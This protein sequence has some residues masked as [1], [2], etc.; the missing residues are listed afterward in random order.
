MP[1]PANLPQSQ[2]K[3]QPWK[4]FIKVDETSVATHGPKSV[5]GS[6]LRVLAELDDKDL[7]G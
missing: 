2:I 3:A 1:P 7:G 5:N 6:E 4:A